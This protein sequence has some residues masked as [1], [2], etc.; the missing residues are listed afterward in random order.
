MDAALQ[1]ASHAVTVVG[2][3]LLHAS[4]HGGIVALA[5][6]TLLSLAR[7]T[8]AWVRAAV[9]WLVTARFVLAVV[10]IPAMDLPILP[11]RS[12]ATLPAAVAARQPDDVPLRSSD[13]MASTTRPA[14]TPSDALADVGTGP[15]GPGVH[16]R[17]PITSVGWMLLVLG[18]IGLVA[19]HIARDIADALSL[20]RLVTTS[21]PADVALT[22]QARALAA[23]C[24]LARPPDV[25]LHPFV[26]SPLVMSPMRPVVI[27]PDSAPGALSRHELELALA[28]EFAHLRRRDLWWAWVPAMT[29]R[30]FAWHPLAR[31]AVREYL[32]AREAACDADAIRSLN[33]EPF[34][35]GNLLLKLGVARRS[36]AW[37]LW[38][39]AHTV[40]TLKRRL[41]MLDH[42]SSPAVRWVPGA[43]AAAALA[44]LPL[45]LSARVTIPAPADVAPFHVGL[46]T[47]AGAA[48]HDADVHQGPPPPPPPAPA[49]PKPPPP[50][51]PPADEVRTPWVLFTEGLP[52]THVNAA[53]STDV[54]QARRA[55]KGDEA[56][57]WFRQDGQ[58]YVIRD[59]ALIEEVR[60]Q[61]AEVNAMGNRMKEAG[62]RM[63]ALGGRTGA[64]GDRQS[65][66]MAALGAAQAAL[67]SRLAQLTGELL[68]VE[69]E[70][71]RQGGSTPSAI[72][73]QE[74]QQMDRVRA[75]IDEV[76]REMEH[77]GRQQEALGE[78][79]RG[80]GDQ[81][82][83]E[84]RQLEVL[85]EQLRREVDA[86][87]HTVGA[88]LRSAVASGHAQLVP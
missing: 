5:A 4:L 17:I 83:A 28:H 34:A 55:R 60:A 30:V 23:R 18:W 61:F 24:G 65:S 20:R 67:G 37:A 15:T 33:S 76:R 27:L 38:G 59:R 86:A 78:E 72:S 70:R 57:L 9:W 14:T 71:L 47:T 63:E 69:G 84:G 7:S 36:P 46:A 39:A 53:R 77:L 25:R 73:E 31:L 11:E 48:D 3:T 51:P 80:W 8:P 42:P 19:R 41:T 22:E 26:R 21:Q 1:S 43:V 35:Y 54:D 29:Q 44:L 16:A 62:G 45:T 32:L 85:G 2:S 64:D 58:A 50:P 68:V 10:P 75:Q 49:P 88:L 12:V 56:L 6:W 82:R 81:L 13:A 74:R 79:M 66:R 40:T 87:Q 52:D